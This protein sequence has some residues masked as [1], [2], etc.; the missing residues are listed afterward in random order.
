LK[1]CFWVFVG[2]FFLS[3]LALWCFV[4]LVLHRD[5]SFERDYLQFYGGLVSEPPELLVAWLVILTPV[6]VYE[7]V[8]SCIYYYRHP[9]QIREIFRFPRRRRP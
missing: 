1:R 5:Y 6:V 3:P 7:F 8:V 4:I 2:S 9:D